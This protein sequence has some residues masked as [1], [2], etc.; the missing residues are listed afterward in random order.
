MDTNTDLY[1]L[2]INI[3][4]YEGQKFIDFGISHQFTVPEYY[5]FLEIG[6]TFS[7]PYEEGMDIFKETRFFEGNLEGF[8]EYV[9]NHDAYNL[10]KTRD[11]SDRN[12]GYG[13][14]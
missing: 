14:W 1:L 5:E 4:E 8:L 2:Q 11:V 7:Y 10:V 3:N 6:F 9:Q 12:I 13:Y